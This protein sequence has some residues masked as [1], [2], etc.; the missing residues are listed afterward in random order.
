[1]LVASASSILMF[2]LTWL[3][4]HTLIHSSSPVGSS[5]VLR[6]R[7]TDGSMH[8]IS[9]PTSQSE[10]ITLDQ[11]VSDFDPSAQ[12]LLCFHQKLPTTKTD[13]ATIP[14]D[15]NQ[16]ISQLNLQ[17]GSLIQLV[18]TAT[19]SSDTPPSPSLQHTPAFDPF[20]HLSKRKNIKSSRRHFSPRT[21]FN[22]LSRLEQLRSH[23]M[24][25]LSTV[26]LSQES[27]KV[28]SVYM[29][30]NVAQRFLQSWATTSSAS[31]NNSIPMALLLGTI[32]PV[33]SSTRSVYIHAL[34]IPPPLYQEIIP[35][36]L[37]NPQSI[38]EKDDSA[39]IK[40]CLSEYN[41]M[42]QLASTLGLQ[43]VGWIYAHDD[44]LP[45][46]Q[47]LVPFQGIYLQ[48]A[49]WGQ[50]YTMKQNLISD[51]F[52]T[53]TMN[54]ISGSTEAFQVHDE[55]VQMFA[56]GLIHLTTNT[57]NNNNPLQD[58]NNNHMLTTLEP[59]CID[60]KE[61]Q[62]LDS[63]FVCKNTAILKHVG[64]FS[65]RGDEKSPVDLHGKLNPWGCNKIQKVLEMDNDSSLIQNLCDFQLL[66]ALDRLVSKKDQMELVFMVQEYVRRGYC[67]TRLGT[68][69][70][71]VLEHVVSDFKMN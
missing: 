54:R 26:K 29:C 36:I 38:S 67:E 50:I 8:R 11:I 5:I 33:N 63:I 21:S 32:D 10:T 2:L 62:E 70:K 68:R 71:L 14:L 35:S 48:Y 22:S 37:W 56:E 52:L 45:Q 65:G 47:K 57:N 58:S 12:K 60:G 9:V 34:W 3:C 6:L 69:L 43:V 1:M 42:V 23:T 44:T 66:L 40:K 39:K 46:Q 16:S 7:D 24:H 59:I 61:T 49:A 19:A 53:L 20:P 55:C 17:H 4:S 30:A 51:T 41:R 27:S 64:T 13:T 15:R 28:S 25:T 18:A 31:S